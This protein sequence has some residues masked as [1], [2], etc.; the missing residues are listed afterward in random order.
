MAETAVGILVIRIHFR[1]LVNLVIPFGGQQHAIAILH[2]P[3]VARAIAI[4]E[5]L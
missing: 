3:G 4:V 5:R 2:F 1:V